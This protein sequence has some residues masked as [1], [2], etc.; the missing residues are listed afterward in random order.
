MHASIVTFST[1]AHI[2]IHCDEHKST[3]RD[4]L[5]KA[6]LDLQHIGKMGF[7]NLRDGLIKG[8][9]ALST[10]GCGSDNAKQIMVVISDGCANRGNGGIRGILDEASEI[11]KD[12]I[13]IIALGV[14][15]KINL[16][17]LKNMTENASLVVESNRLN[18]RVFEQATEIL[19][20]EKCK[21]AEG[22]V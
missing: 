13:E 22:L 21:T 14:G 9:E 18:E 15:K 7:T 12:G 3:G 6:V 4:T 11:R 17:V 16:D 20:S 2:R 19:S 8:R 5:E 10:R 1:N